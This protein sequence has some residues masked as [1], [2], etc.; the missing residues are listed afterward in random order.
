MGGGIAIGRRSKNEKRGKAGLICLTVVSR[1]YIKELKEMKELKELKELSH[2][3][4]P[5]IYERVEAEEESEGDRCVE[6]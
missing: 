1:A 2:C 6:D 4:E 3:S 5:G